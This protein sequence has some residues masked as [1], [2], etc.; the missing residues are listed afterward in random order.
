MPETFDFDLESLVRVCLNDPGARAQVER[1]LAAGPLPV[2]E[3]TVQVREGAKLYVA[4]LKTDRE[5]S[6]GDD[7]FLARDT[8]GRF[9]GVLT[10]VVISDHDASTMSQDELA[11]KLGISVAEL[12]DRLKPNI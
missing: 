7:G 8:R 10:E 5:K 12:A 3:P 1:A 11:K 4:R 2:R 6:P 9:T